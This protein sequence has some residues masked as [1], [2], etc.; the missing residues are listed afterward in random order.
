MPGD[1]VGGGVGVLVATGTVVGVGVMVPILEVEG[2]VNVV[3]ARVAPPMTTDTVCD[4]A[5]ADGTV[6]FTPKFPVCP[7]VVKLDN[8]GPPSQT[9]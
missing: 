6:T 4:P 5:L 8:S 7:L 9:R 3:L 1:V 2:I